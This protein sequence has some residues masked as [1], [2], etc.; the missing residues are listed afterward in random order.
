[1]KFFKCKV[2]SVYEPKK[3]R[4]NVVHCPPYRYLILLKPREEKFGFV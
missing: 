4:N 2:G 3:L 1:M